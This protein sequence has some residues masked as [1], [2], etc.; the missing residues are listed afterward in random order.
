[1]EGFLA[2]EKRE[3]G[4]SLIEAL[5]SLVVLGIGLLGLAQ[6]QARLWSASAD[7]HSSDEA[8]LLASNSLEQFAIAQLFSVDHS[9]DSTT[10]VTGSTTQFVVN[11]TLTKLEQIAEA[12]VQVEWAHQRGLRSLTLDSAI[13]TSARAAD[14]RLLLAQD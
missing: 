3:H 1:V 14:N 13:C 10:R 11:L 8:Y 5:I 7:L 12:R 2:M 4:F 6:L 9:A